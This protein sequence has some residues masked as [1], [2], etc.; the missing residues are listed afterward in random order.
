M[1]SRNIR[2]RTSKPEVPVPVSR[3]NT[4]L[5]GRHDD[6]ALNR[7]IEREPDRSGNEG[8]LTWAGNVGLRE[9]CVQPKTL[10]VDDSNSLRL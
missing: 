1:D 9:A 3:G 8:C 4:S 10:L 7:C 6:I 5:E 2:I